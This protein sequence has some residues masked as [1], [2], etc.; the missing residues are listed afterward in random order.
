MKP[1]PIPTAKKIA[2]DCGAT[3]VLVLMIDDDGNWAF[4][5]YGRTQEQCQ[6]MAAWADCRAED[7]AFEM[8]EET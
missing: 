4:T 7:I 3:R 6:K 8:N 1:A 2:A 5:T